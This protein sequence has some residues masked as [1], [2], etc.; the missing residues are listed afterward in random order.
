MATVSPQAEDISL[1]Y[2]GHL[3]PLRIHHLMI[4]TALTAAILGGCMG[5]GWSGPGWSSI[6]D[7]FIVAVLVVFAVV[8]A[9]VLTIGASAVEWRRRGIVF[10]RSP[11]DMLLV[12]MAGGVLGFFAMIG[13]LFFTVWIIGSGGWFALCYIIIVGALALLGW[14]YLQIAGMLHYS[15]TWP[16]R[17]VFGILLLSPWMIGFFP[18]AILVAFI[19]SVLCASWVDW[20]KSLS[21]AWTHWCGASFAILLGI[22]LLCVVVRAS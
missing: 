15:N 17:V 20:R 14:S 6:D 4:W 16:W 5:F 9:G 18:M 7:P 12:S 22:S 13:L 10:P 21:R 2:N 8:A 3:P 1:G 19:A 11:G